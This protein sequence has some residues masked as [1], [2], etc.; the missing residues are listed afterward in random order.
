MKDGNNDMK[1][2]NFKIVPESLL[3]K[4]KPEECFTYDKSKI[5]SLT[6]TSGCKAARCGYRVAILARNSSIEGTP[7]GDGSG[8]QT[9]RVVFYP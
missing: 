5:P 6:K 2:P 9:S 8:E 4:Y 3:Q 1:D 7:L